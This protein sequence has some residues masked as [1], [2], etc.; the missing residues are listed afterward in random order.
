MYVLSV[1]ER[2]ETWCKS[3]LNHAVARQLTPR[4]IVGGIPPGSRERIRGISNCSHGAF[5]TESS[6]ERN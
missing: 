1:E 4:R 6:I 2:V 3:E 5:S